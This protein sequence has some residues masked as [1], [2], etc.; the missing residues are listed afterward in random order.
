MKG[1]SS[2]SSHRTKSLNDVFF[3]ST[4]RNLVCICVLNL[5]I[6]LIQSRSDKQEQLGEPFGIK[7]Y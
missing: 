6:D 1:Q 4:E 7:S 2:H 3:C 5:F